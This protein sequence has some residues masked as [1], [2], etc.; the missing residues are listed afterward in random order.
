MTTSHTPIGYKGPTN[1]AEL[2]HCRVLEGRGRSWEINGQGIAQVALTCFYMLV[3]FV[4]PTN[5]IDPIKSF[6]SNDPVL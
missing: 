5:L 6:K 1:Q 3:I 4:K 2:H